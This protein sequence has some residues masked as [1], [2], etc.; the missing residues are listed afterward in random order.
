MHQLKLILNNYIFSILLL[1]TLFFILQFPNL[2]LT[3]THGGDSP[4][5][6]VFNHLFKNDFQSSVSTIFPHGPLDFLTTSP[7]SYNLPAYFTIYFIVKF[8][9]IFLTYYLNK[10]INKTTN[11]L[12]IAS[13][14]YFI[15][16]ISDITFLLILCTLFAL[17]IFFETTNKRWKYLAFSIIALSLFIRVY[18]SVIELSIGFSFLFYDFFYTKKIKQ[19]LYD[20]IIL[21]LFIILSYVALFHKISGISTFLFG[22]LNLAMDNSS[23]CSYYPSNNWWLIINSLFIIVFIPVINNSKQSLFFGALTALPIFCAFKHGMSREEWVHV[24]GF[25]IF[26]LLIFICFLFYVR[27]KALLN[28]TLFITSFSLLFINFNNYTF[29]KYQFPTYPICSLNNFIDFVS[30]YDEIVKKSVVQIE[31][32]IGYRKLSTQLKEKI[33]QTSVDVYPW[34]YSIIAINKFN[35]HPRPILNS[36]A[37][38][39]SWLDKQDEY[40]FNSDKAPGFL[41]WDFSLGLSTSIN[42]TGL[43]SIDDRYLLNDEPQTLISILA[44][45][46]FIDYE[47]NL[48]IYQKRENP[49][50]YYSKKEKRTTA[51]INEWVTIPD[52]LKNE[53]IRANLF[54]TKTFLQRL[55]S[56]FYK[57][58]QYWIYL[59]LSDRSIQKIKIVPKNAQNGIWINPFIFQSAM[60]NEKLCVKEFMIK[61]SNEDI[62]N[63]TFDFQFESYSFKERGIMDSFFPNTKTLIDINYFDSYNI[64]NNNI[65]Q[66]LNVEEKI[67]PN[68]N[69]MLFPDQFSNSYDITIDSCKFIDVKST[70]WAI[71][72]HKQLNYV[73]VFKDNAD[74]QIEWLSINASE[75][76]LN[77]SG[78]EL[79]SFYQNIPYNK[80][81]KKLSVSLWNTSKKDTV[82]VEDFNLKVNLLN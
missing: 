3:F 72:P 23:A 59:K 27:T 70:C 18:I 69:F 31:N 50:K 21:F 10:H 26:L 56:F 78:K 63:K 16:L 68:K 46:K 77:N 13:F 1:N 8:I 43:N 38:Y 58:E 82:K 71:L 66:G 75:Q 19:L 28:I 39:T 14:I 49:L 11:W 24:S 47:N 80:N 6:W 9:F 65:N 81:I 60:R 67:N 36:Y 12:V 45:Y 37:A 53:I 61:N 52:T 41:I 17:L 48:N 25:F 76:S 42:E 7:L 5:V 40:Y 20:M 79:Y 34:D 51:I 74:N 44:N 35:W 22:I 62:L 29:N 57:D 54:F 73:F 55:K 30:N 64:S 2:E 33:G 32:N 4:L 15:F